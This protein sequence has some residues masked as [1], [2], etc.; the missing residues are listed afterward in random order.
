MSK[1]LQTKMNDNTLEKLEKC[2]AAGCTVLEA[3]S[4]AEISKSTFYNYEQANPEW[5]EY[6]QALQAR[7]IAEARM[8]LV[9]GLKDNPELALKFLERVKKDEF[10]TKVVN[11]V[12][13]DVNITI[14]WVDSETRQEFIDR[15]ADL[16]PA[17]MI[18][19]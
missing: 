13:Q 4:V 16:I 8:I 18:T 11:Q 12:D 2:F 1:R 19:N 7:T 10:S 14:T 5:R 6:R 3:C 15:T 9:N 17:S